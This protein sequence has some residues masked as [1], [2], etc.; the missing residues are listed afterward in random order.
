MKRFLFGLAAAALLALPAASARAQTYHAQPYKYGKISS[1]DAEWESLMRDSKRYPMEVLQ[2]EPQDYRLDNAVYSDW[3]KYW[4]AAWQD[5][6]WH[7]S[8]STFGPQPD[9]FRWRFASPALEGVNRPGVPATLK[10][11]R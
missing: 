10:T 3:N 5:P 1:V 9:P 11:T 2:H 6:I 8:L 7:M 4:R